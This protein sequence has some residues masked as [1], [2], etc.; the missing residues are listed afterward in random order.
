MAQDTIRA[1]LARVAATLGAPEGV[2]VE[3]ET[4]RDKTHGDVATNLAMTL[5]PDFARDWIESL[6]VKHPEP[7]GEDEIARLRGRK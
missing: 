6:R 2:A 1:E 3:L 4:P 5:P 7:L